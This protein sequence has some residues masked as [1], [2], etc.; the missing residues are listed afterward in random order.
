MS[1]P[2]DWDDWLRAQGRRGGFL[3]SS[4]W[5]RIL[6]A[7][8]GATAQVQRTA[9]AGALWIAR[10]APAT[11]GLRGLA[12]KALG[13]AAGGTLECRDGPVLPA[14]GGAEALAELLAGAPDFARDAG[15]GQIVVHPP[16]AAGWA[17]DDATRAAFAAAG[18]SEHEWLTALVPLDRDDDEIRSGL[19]R[20]A[21]KA[22]RKAGEAGATVR[23]LDT[24]DEIEERFLRTY[25]AWAGIDAP[26]WVERVGLAMVD[27][28]DAGV[29]TWLVVESDAGDPLAT[30]GTYRFAGVATEVMSARAPE[31]PV[32]AQDLIHWEALRHHRDAGDELFDLAGFAPDPGDPKE[33]GIRRFKEK[34]GGAVVPNPRY[35]L[36]L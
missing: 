22:V 16:V 12:K 6:A 31:T 18:Y 9:T 26:D 3:Q 4:G 5:A 11:A 2:P 10:P 24:R 30:L 28:D 14:D 34:W 32:P 25:A 36:T 13:R 21:R 1:A 23:R 8:D 7:S 35:E 33:A 29:Y 27:R 19:N 15:A 17:G 20:S